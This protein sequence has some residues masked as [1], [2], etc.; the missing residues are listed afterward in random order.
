MSSVSILLNGTQL[1]VTPV[2]SSE[3]V[4]ATSIVT[5]RYT[6]PLRRDMCN[7]TVRTPLAI[8]SHVHPTPATTTTDTA[9]IRGRLVWHKHHSTLSQA[10]TM[11][12]R[13]TPFLSCD[14]R[15]CLSP[16]IAHAKRISQGI[17]LSLCQA[18]RGCYITQIDACT[19][20]R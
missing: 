3:S 19:D 12:D 11:Q 6:N 20:G 2:P 15:I 5:S 17:L 16:G 4:V 9:M 13:K 10:I 14:D 7:N 1:S 18:R 8:Y